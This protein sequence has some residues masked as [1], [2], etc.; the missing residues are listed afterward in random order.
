M[1]MRY[2]ILLLALFT[3]I[4]C[5]NDDNDGQDEPVNC[6]EVFVQGLNVQVKDASTGSIIPQGIAVTITDGDYT[7]ELSFN[8]DTFFGA[9]E[10][11]G[12]YTITAMGENYITKTVGP[13]VVTED[14]CHVI[15]VSVEISLTPN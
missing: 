7:E 11:A 4:S 13:I 3:F 6:T 5:S 10:R 1:D 9:G 15:P 2:S 14:E 12:N 8:F